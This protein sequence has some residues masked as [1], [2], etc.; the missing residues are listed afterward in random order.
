[1]KTL[2]QILIVTSFLIIKFSCQKTTGQFVT[3][4]PISD[5]INPNT[6]L[7]GAIV[8]LDS[9]III[10]NISNIII[11]GENKIYQFTHWE[12]D[13]TISNSFNITLKNFNIDYNP[14]PHSEGL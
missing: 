14:I 10:S 8:T 13:I 3:T 11:D 12:D 2:Y 9:S 4:I 1:M 7:T 5:F 6:N